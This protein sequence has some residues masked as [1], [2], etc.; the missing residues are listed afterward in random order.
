MENSEI[1]QLFVSM[2]R[3]KINE[4]DENQKAVYQDIC[5]PIIEEF[6]KQ[7]YGR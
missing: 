1:G 4:K 7:L 3:Y 2:Q 6:R 5:N